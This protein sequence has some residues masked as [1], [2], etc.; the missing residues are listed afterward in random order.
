MHGHPG[1]LTFPKPLSREALRTLGER[2]M[3]GQLVFRCLTLPL[4]YS[5]QKC[6]AQL[7]RRPPG[8]TTPCSPE[9]ESFHLL[10]P[11]WLWVKMSYLSL[12]QDNSGEIKLWRV[13]VEDRVTIPPPL[14]LLDFSSIKSHI[15]RSRNHDTFRLANTWVK[16]VKMFFGGKSG[17][18]ETPKSAGLWS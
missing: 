7:I 17:L 6:L 13:F 15:P 14:N 10:L 3:K 16:P 4:K 9:Q 1:P 8:G 11:L 2:A 5:P 12:F 18:L